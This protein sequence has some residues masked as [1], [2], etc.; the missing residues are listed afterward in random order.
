MDTKIFLAY[1]SNLASSGVRETIRYLVQHRMVDVLITTAGGVE[2][3]LIKCLAPTYVGD[4]ALQGADLRSR[5]LNRIGNM[6]ARRS[7]G[8]GW[9]VVGC[10]I[11]RRLS[12]AAMRVCPETPA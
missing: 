7:G 11:H 12:V 1:T 10:P 8:R 3:D 6:L 9:A 5:G 2:E 4:F